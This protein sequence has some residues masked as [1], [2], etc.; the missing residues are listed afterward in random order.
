MSWHEHEHETLP[1]RKQV[2]ISDRGLLVLGVAAIV[3]AL[4][5]YML[6]KVDGKE[7]ALLSTVINC[8]TVEILEVN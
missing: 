4:F 2:S 6:G 7:D 8:A 5:M 3:V 1:V